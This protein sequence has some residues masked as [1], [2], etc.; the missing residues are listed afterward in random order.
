MELFNILGVIALSILA[1]WF[2][3]LG[4]TGGAWSTCGVN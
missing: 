4:G 1:G 2:Y 3:H